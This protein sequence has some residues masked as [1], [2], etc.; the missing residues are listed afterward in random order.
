MAQNVNTYSVVPGAFPVLT[1]A[2]VT[3]TTLA[4]ATSLGTLTRL[5]RQIAFVSTLNADTW[6]VMNGTALMPLP[7]SSSVVL[8]AGAD[9]EFYPVGTIFSV[10][11]M[12]GTPT[13]GWM[14]LAPL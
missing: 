8:D 1:Y 3:V 12:S 14:G 4:S 7:A 6:L 13:S 9:G 11:C 2:S 5:C 10:Y